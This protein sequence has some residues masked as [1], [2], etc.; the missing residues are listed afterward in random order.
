MRTIVQV[1]IENRLESCETD[2][3]YIYLGFAGASGAENGNQGLLGRITCAHG[4]GRGIEQGAES[5]KEWAQHSFLAL[6]FAESAP[7]KYEM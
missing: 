6:R 4:G 2:E 1:E 7:E 5:V 3:R